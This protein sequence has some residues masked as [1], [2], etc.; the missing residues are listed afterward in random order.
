MGRRIE[1]QGR[2]TSAVHVPVPVPAHLP[3]S[4]VWQA[5]LRGWQAHCVW[6]QTPPNGSRMDGL[7]ERGALCSRDLRLSCYDSPLFV[8]QPYSL[9]QPGYGAQGDRKLLL[10]TRVGGATRKVRGGG[11][12]AGPEGSINL[13]PPQ[14]LIVSRTFIRNPRGPRLRTSLHRFTLA[15]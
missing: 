3:V 4:G 9:P 11:R 2:R 10:P 13:V 1:E 14:A 6:W 7:K 8:R 5:R 12:K 15:R